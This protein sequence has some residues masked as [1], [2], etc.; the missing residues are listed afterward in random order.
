MALPIAAMFGVVVCSFEILVPW[1][2]DVKV[3]HKQTWVLCV[4]KP[5]DFPLKED[6]LANYFINY[7]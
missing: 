4:T 7:V 1:T 2:R 6:Y 3:R 5:G